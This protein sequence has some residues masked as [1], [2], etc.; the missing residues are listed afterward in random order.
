MAGQVDG[1]AEVLGRARIAVGR[2]EHDELVPP[3][4]PVVEPRFVA[5]IPCFDGPRVR[6]RERPAEECGAQA[7]V[8]AAPNDVEPR[9]DQ[10]VGLVRRLQIVL[11]ER[12]HH[13]QLLSG[14]P[15]GTCIL[16]RCLEERPDEVEVALFVSLWEVEKGQ[17]DD[18]SDRWSALGQVEEVEGRVG[19]PLGL[20]GPV[21]VVLAAQPVEEDLEALVRIRRRGLLEGL[22]EL[23]PVPGDAVDEDRMALLVVHPPPRRAGRGRRDRTTRASPVLLGW[24]NLGPVVE[25]PLPGVNQSSAARSDATYSR[26]PPGR[27]RGRPRRRGCRRRSR[28][29][30]RRPRPPAR[31]SR[32]RSRRAA[33]PR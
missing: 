9:V 21:R 7:L 16:E 22:H 31:A 27:P 23:P 20:V 2:K 32:C 25:R 19:A 3:R 13:A 17:R 8:L 26:R 15:L 29:R 30:A 28:R 12:H 14:L 6:V 10:R 1:D 24:G 11:Q 18:V 4:D 33:G 5:Q